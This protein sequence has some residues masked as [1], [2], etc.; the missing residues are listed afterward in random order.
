MKNELS[1]RGLFGFLGGIG[2]VA[3]AP[4][5][6]TAAPNN[7]SYTPDGVVDATVLWWDGSMGHARGDDNRRYSI[8]SSVLADQ[9]N[10]RA[11]ARIRLQLRTV[12]T[13][14]VMHM[15]TI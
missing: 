10:L 13:H 9:T 11:G 4:I 8:D 1:R 7:L 15:K 2:A 3:A 5:V 6:A 12:D 14:S